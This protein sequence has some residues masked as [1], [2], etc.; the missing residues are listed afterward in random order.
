M[1]MPALIPSRGRPREFDADEALTAALKVFWTL[2]YEG[3]SLTDLT[4]AMGISRP[5]LYA[6]FGNKESLYRKALDLYER[7]K[8]AYVRTALDAP[9]ARAV[10]ETLL[11]G[12]LDLFTG[13]GEP[14]G[15]FGVISAVACGE[16]ARS[17]RADVIAKRAAAN[18]ALIQRFQAA[19]ADGDLPGHVD[20]DALAKWLSAVSQGMAVQAGAGASR[21]DLEQVIETSLQF[22]PT[23]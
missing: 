15:C 12:A 17:I 3:A 16:E 23:R 6:A 1:N 7:E 11:R 18:A 9:T 19:K 5:S 2:G 8:L 10:A 4:D 20:P 21:S 22:W 13:V 14:K